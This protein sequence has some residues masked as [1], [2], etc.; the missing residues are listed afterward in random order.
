MAVCHIPEMITDRNHNLCVLLDKSFYSID[1]AAQLYKE[2]VANVTYDKNSVVKIFGKSIPIPRKQ[3][4]YGDPG[5]TYTFS[6]VT[7]NAKPWIP[8]IL[9]IKADVEY[10]LGLQFNFC[11][12]NKYDTGE[13]YI[14][15]HKDDEIDLGQNP[16]IASVSFGQERKFYF[17]SDD[18]NVPVTKLKLSS[19]TLCV[20]Y[21]P[22]NKNYKHSVPKEVKVTGCRINLT[23]RHIQI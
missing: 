14:G 15:Y 5:T 17:K 7:V 11:L 8:I 18:P 20:M 2:L 19:G 10:I 16:A 1:D 21:D 6:N 23:F 13:N 9:K 22:T 3:T 12:V 4:A